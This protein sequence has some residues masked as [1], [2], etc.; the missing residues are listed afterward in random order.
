MKFFIS[1]KAKPKRTREEIDEDEEGEWKTVTTGTTISAEKPKM[2]AKDA[3]IDAAVVIAKLNEVRN[4]L[5]NSII[6][7]YTL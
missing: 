6:I 4:K 5:L 2:F 7:Y 3:E 1:F